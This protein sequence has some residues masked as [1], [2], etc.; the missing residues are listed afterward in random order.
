MP[1]GGNHKSIC[2]RLIS[3]LSTVTIT[4]A[5]DCS[6]S[7]GF[8]HTPL[9]VPLCG[10]WRHSKGLAL[11]KGKYGFL[12]SMTFPLDASCPSELASFIILLAWSLFFSPIPSPPSCVFLCLKSDG[13][14]T[15]EQIVRKV[16]LGMRNKREVQTYLGWGQ[17]FWQNSFG[18]LF[19]VA[20]ICHWESGAILF[21]AHASPI[22]L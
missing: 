11:D 15:H 9:W 12:K 2:Y 3:V 13:A 17:M 4:G 19:E 18:V 21:P 7:E 22:E 20:G 8:F 5:S 16:S 1:G 14:R 6:F 10:F